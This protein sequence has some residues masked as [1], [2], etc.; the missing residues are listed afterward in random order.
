MT[1]RTTKIE[2]LEN[3]GRDNLWNI[4]RLPIPLNRVPDRTINKLHAKIQN[5]KQ[6]LDEFLPRIN[7]RLKYIDFINVKTDKLF[8]L[9]KRIK[10]R[11]DQ[12]NLRRLAPP[13]FR[14]VAAF[15]NMISNFNLIIN[16][17]NRHLS[18]P[19]LFDYIKDEYRNI[20]NRNVN[21][22]SIKAQIRIEV[23]LIRA[24][25]ITSS[26]FSTFLN[27][28]V[29][30]GE[31]ERVFNTQKEKIIEQ[32]D[33]STDKGSGWIFYSLNWVTIQIAK[34][35]PLRG[36]SYLI[37]PK[38]LANKKAIINPKNE[39][40]Q[41]F[42]YALIAGW[43]YNQNIKVHLERVT[44]LKKYE[45]MINIDLSNI[46]YPVTL[47]K[48]QFVQRKNP[49]IQINVYG[50]DDNQNIC[51]LI[52]CKNSPNAY[53][54]FLIPNADRF[55]GHYT[56]IHDMNKLLRSEQSKHNEKKYHCL[57]CMHGFK[58]Q[59]LLDNHIE[60][61]CGQQRVTL[62]P[63]GSTL[64][65]T[66]NAKRHLV[67]FVIYCDAESILKQLE[68]NKQ[69]L[70]TKTEIK[71]GKTEDDLPYTNYKQLHEPCSIAGY[72]SSIE[73]PSI[74]QYWY[75][76]GK[77]PIQE[78]FKFL[79]D[80]AE[81]IDLMRQRYPKPYLNVAE[82]AE[83][84][85]ATECYL[86]HKEFT[87][88]DYKVR[89]H[90]HVTGKYR[91]ASH[92]SCNK[93][94]RQMS[95]IPV[96]FH[97]LKGYDSHLIIQAI[98]EHHNFQISVIANNIENFKTFSLDR[99]KFIDSFQ[100]MA[101]SLEK[102]T[103]NLKK[104]S[105]DNFI[106]F[107]QKIKDFDLLRKGVYP[108]SF[109]DSFDKFNDD[110][111]PDIKY[112]YNDLKD[113]PCN[114]KDY[115]WGLHIFKTKCKTMKDYHDLYLKAD[116]I[117]LA[118]IFN[119]F[120]MMCKDYYDL[121][122]AHYLSAPHMAWDGLLKFSN[123]ELELITDPDIYSIFEQGLR[124]GISMITK[125]LATKTAN[126]HINYLD[127]NNLYGHSMSQLLPVS[128]FKFNQDV[129]TVDKILSIGAENPIGYVF[130]V[131][132]EYPHELHD[133]H[134][135]YPLLPEKMIITDNY[136]SEYQLN[137]KRK[138]NLKEDRIAKLVP[139]LNNKTNYII[140]YRNLQQAINLGLKLTKIH[141]VVE[142][143][144]APWMKSYI[145][146][147]TK[148]RQ[149]SKNDFEKDFFKLMNNSAF[150]KT[151]EDLRKRFHCEIVNQED[152]A[153][154]LLSKITL[155][156]NRI[157]NDDLCIMSFTKLSIELNKP[158]YTGFSV[159]DLSKLLMYDFHYNVMKKNFDCDLL[160][161]DTDSLAYEVKC[162][163][164]QY[165]EKILKLKNFFDTSN[166]PVDHLLYNTSNKMIVGKFKE[167]HPLGIDEFIGLR[168][169]MYSLFRAQ[170]L[171]EDNKTVKVT[172]LECN[173]GKGIKSNVLKSVINHLNYSETLNKS[174]QQLFTMKT[175]RSENHHIYTIEQRKTGLSAFDNKRYIL[176]DG[177]RSLAH[178]HKDI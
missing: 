137:L 149:E 148:K 133:L 70:L 55:N 79:I 38:K 170:V 117:L 58:N 34:Y 115:Q 143:K 140:H 99:F 93:A 122:P 2:F 163:T 43:C 30:I 90:S 131:D 116:V 67:P 111:F 144:Q 9:L 100:F 94:Y 10:K 85:K 53:N 178:G 6:Y 164:K 177:I 155:K 125:R 32:Y 69:R 135:D 86:C 82:K 71:L 73:D 138:F 154:K 81:Y 76:L 153:K 54:L 3:A 13:Q 121:D 28:I 105:M 161:T 50:Y 95:N 78:F 17:G 62:P 49:N 65:F 103:E 123:I 158:I 52:E 45:S 136:L 147:N 96:I 145:E 169:K 33:V 80:S 107:K 89:D 171:E 139:N 24:G 175:L 41:C 166:Y 119:K 8:D 112:F 98:K 124:G 35:Q 97:N 167:E 57:R 174:I 84:K 176:A 1:N 7:N 130:Q 44:V 61:G 60:I 92:S 56:F 108:Y 27:A 129:W 39:D 40:N 48:I 142:F 5:R 106:C 83:F 23:N 110:K 157:I 88:S 150:G 37:T 102:L 31:F 47:D 14:Q 21:L 18:P 63:I 160:F 120:R 46:Y 75:Y 128:D 162:P 4:N 132:I 134:N 72:I 25:T 11:Q 87:I 22:Q 118:D 20:V 29:N 15:R 165:Y 51:P 104:D 77:D 141:R 173:K 26:R 159:L 168:P 146:F 59:E 101:S 113:E 126:N 64:K 151:M 19:I 74:N 127:A 172:P 152:R 114:E 109:F 68:D 42:K 91:G 12:V 156:E 36:S 66:N 16:D